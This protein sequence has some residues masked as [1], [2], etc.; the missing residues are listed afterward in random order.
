MNPS[1]ASFIQGGLHVFTA[2]LDI[3]NVSETLLI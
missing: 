1:L 2:P 3:Q